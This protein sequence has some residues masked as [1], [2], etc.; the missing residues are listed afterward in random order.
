M[1]YLRDVIG[2][3]PPGPSVRAQAAQCPTTGGAHREN[4]RLELPR[5]DLKRA[6]SL[7]VQPAEALA[8]EIP[9]WSLEKT[10]REVLPHEL[11]LSAGPGR[12]APSRGRP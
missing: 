9:N 1:T 8:A 7:S 11:T 2:G 6:W 4:A 12:P 10:K 3:W 5:K